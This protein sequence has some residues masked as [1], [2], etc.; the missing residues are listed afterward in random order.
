MSTLRA[1]VAVTLLFIHTAHSHREIRSFHASLLLRFMCFSIH[2]ERGDIFHAG[3]RRKHSEDV[4]T[5]DGTKSR[6]KNYV[7]QLQKLAYTLEVRILIFL[8]LT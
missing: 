5:R 2:S 7:V 3:N 6:E 1:T 8:L 4:H